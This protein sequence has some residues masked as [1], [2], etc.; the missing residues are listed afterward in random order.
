MGATAR[1]FSDGIT[2]N[3]LMPGAIAPGIRVIRAVLE[4]HLSGRRQ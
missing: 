1:W 2:A 3:A 4:P